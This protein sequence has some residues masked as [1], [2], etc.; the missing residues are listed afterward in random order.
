MIAYGYIAL[1]QFPKFEK[2]VLAAEMRQVMWVTHRRIRKSSI[3]RIHRKIRFMKKCYERETITAD[4]IRAS[5]TSWLAH[6]SHA[7]SFGLRKSILD[8]AVFIR[9]LDHQT[10][11]TVLLPKIEDRSDVKT[12]IK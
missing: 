2:H 9:Q 3:S 8:K 4:R 12:C 6:A 11:C 7:Q 5:I 10:K 1:R